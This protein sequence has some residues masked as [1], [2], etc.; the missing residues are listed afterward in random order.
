MEA[1]PAD[2]IWPPDALQ[3]FSLRMAGHGLSVSSS[4]MR[5]DR[6]YALEQLRL[7]HTLAD[8]GLRELAMALFRAFEQHQS[9]VAQAH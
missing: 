9:G 4:M 8:D 6:R 7:A 3:T 2:G 5:H 1:P